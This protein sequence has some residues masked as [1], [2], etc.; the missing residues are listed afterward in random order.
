MTTASG[1]CLILVHGSF[2]GRWC[3]ERVT[4]MLE[5]AGYRTVAPD[6][7]AAGDLGG[8]VRIVEQA[9][10]AQPGPVVLV[11]HSMGG[12]VTS[13]ICERRTERIIG[14]V[15]VAGL[16]LRN[17]ETLTSFLAAHEALGIVDLVLKEMQVDPAGLVASFPPAAAPAVFYNACTAEDAEW[18][19]TKL[20]PQ[21]LAVYAD[22]LNLTEARYGSVRRFY[23]AAL[24]DQAVSPTYQRVMTERTLCEDVIW[25]DSDHSPFL[26]APREFADTL[27]GVLARLVL[28]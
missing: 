23:L 18:A 1:V 20:R 17:G 3:W 27:S 25:L 16:M 4:P 5:R 24:R 15:Y 9:I 6:L 12:I 11:G 10:D 26:S 14:A 22:P 7:G 19:S 2:H 13:Q 21:P 28:S 8:Y